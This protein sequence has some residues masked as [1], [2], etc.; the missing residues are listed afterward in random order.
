MPSFQSLGSKTSQASQIALHSVPTHSIQSFRKSCQ[1]YFPSVFRIQPLLFASIWAISVPT[2]VLYCLDCW[3]DP[4]TGFFFL[5][6]LVLP[7]VLCAASRGARSTHAGPRQ[8]SLL[9]ALPRALQPQ[10]E[11]VLTGPCAV[12]LLTSPTLSSCFLDCSHPI[13]WPPCCPLTSWAHSHFKLH[14]PACASA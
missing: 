13:N 2:A 3:H 14:A 4:R 8:P 11:Q 9:Q 10:T 1:L 12:G 7:A 6:V 5:H